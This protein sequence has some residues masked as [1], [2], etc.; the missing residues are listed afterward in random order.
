MT[1]WTRSGGGSGVREVSAP[2]AERIAEG[3]C[4]TVDMKRSPADALLAR[5]R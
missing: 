5:L 3:A 1:V 2:W 4:T